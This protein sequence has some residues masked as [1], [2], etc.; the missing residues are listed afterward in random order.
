MDR[1][2]ARASMRVLR[3][4]GRGNADNEATTRRRLAH[5][6]GQRS[7]EVAPHPMSVTMEGK[8]ALPLGAPR[9]A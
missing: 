4:G 6:R 3:G 7:D 1:A 2:R 8:T 9:W 5:T